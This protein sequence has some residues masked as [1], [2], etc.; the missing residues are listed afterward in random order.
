MSGDQTGDA[1]SVNIG[2]QLTDLN[3]HPDCH[4]VTLCHTLAFSPNFLPW[5]ENVG[6]SVF[7][8]KL[9]IDLAENLNIL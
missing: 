9:S 7:W 6:S 3:K 1:R 2:E 8:D 4:T 5:T